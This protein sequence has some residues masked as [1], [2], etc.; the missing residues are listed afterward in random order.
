MN[1]NTE[2]R[3]LI[4]RWQAASVLREQFPEADTCA[5][6]HACW[7]AFQDGR[8]ECSRTELVE[9]LRHYTPLAEPTGS[10]KRDFRL[11]K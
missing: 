11:K 6:A 8:E 7:R 2:R 3:E 9:A 5:I 1:T 10:A 4:Q